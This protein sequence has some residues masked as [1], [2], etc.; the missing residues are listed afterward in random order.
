M[1]EEPVRLTLCPIRLG[2]TPCEDVNSDTCAG[3][4]RIDRVVGLGLHV[5]VLRC[6]EGRKLM[7]QPDSAVTQGQTLV[8][9]TPSEVPAPTV[10]FV[11]SIP[12]ESFCSFAAAIK[13]R[14]LE[15]ARITAHRVERFQ[16]L[17]QKAERVV[18]GPTQLR[19]TRPE[20]TGR[21]MELQWSSLDTLLP[22]GTIDIQASD[23]IAARILQ[24]NDPAERFLR[25]VPA[26]RDPMQLIDKWKSKQLCEELGIPTPAGTDRCETDSFPTVVKARVGSGGSEVRI[27]HDPEQLA[28]AWQA[29]TDVNGV[30]PILEAFH[31]ESAIRF[32]GV[33]KNGEL[34]VG[35]A[36]EVRPDPHLPLGPARSARA[37]DLPDLVDDVRRLVA[38]T[39]FTGL[40]CIDYVNDPGGP[41]LA[42]D[43]NPR[44]F[45]SWAALQHAGV[46]VIGAYLHSLDLGPRPTQGA[47]D[48]ATWFNMFSFPLPEAT[49]AAALRAR[50]RE[51][52]Q[53]V[54]Q[55]RAI[56]GDTWARLTTARI[57]TYVAKQM[58]KRPWRHHG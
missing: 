28:E 24:S 17:V 10:V 50:R 32:G 6:I 11:D 46:D 44:V 31:P 35:S 39:Q 52:L 58:I 7:S 30:T 2:L 29:L 54:K 19:I 40:M 22:T 41:P 57:E 33:A 14:G 12:W 43:I 4:C 1:V 16:Q 53:L 36:Y 18:F 42:N 3:G 47:V 15:T 38:A 34:L 51:D 49:S 13:Q 56:M 55:N 20:D 5:N 25:R 48:Y 37:I 21:P 8:V 26:D 9:R 23:V 27:A 45:A